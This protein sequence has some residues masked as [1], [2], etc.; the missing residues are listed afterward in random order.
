MTKT[1]GGYAFYDTPF[2]NNQPDGVVYINRVLYT[3]KGK[4]PHNTAISI[5]EGTVSISGFAFRGCSSL[6]SVTI[7][8]SVTRI[9]TY[10]FSG[11]GLISVTIPD[12]VTEIGD[13]AFSDCSGLTSM[14]ISNAVTSIGYQAFYGC[15]SLTSVTIPNSVTSIGTEAFSECSGLTSVTIPNSVTSIGKYA[16]EDCNGLTSL[17]AYPQVPP[18]CSDGAFDGIDKSICKLYVPN[19]CIAV[20][21]AAEQWKEFYNILPQR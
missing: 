14:T 12:T 20:Y 18:V 3:Y 9:D 11:C 8:N 13:W 6:T 4:M 16:F 2:Y 21:Q 15:Y 7:P 10:A 19:N 17:Y 1:G 5:K